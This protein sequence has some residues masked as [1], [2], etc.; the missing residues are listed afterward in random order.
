MYFAILASGFGIAA[1]LNGKFV[2]KY[3]MY[4]LSV[5]GVLGLISTGLLFLIGGGENGHSLVSFMLICYCLMFCAGLIFSNLSAL[6]MQPLGKVAGLG[7]AIISAISSIIAVPV[8]AFAGRF[9]NNT[10]LPLSLAIVL[11][12]I[13]ASTLLFIARRGQDYQVEAAS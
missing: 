9:Y 5:G 7:A 1:L 11:C 2:M 3:G 13:L 12:G 4:K 6:A 8:S 10:L